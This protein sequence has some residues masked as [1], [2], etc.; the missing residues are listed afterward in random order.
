MK[1][2]CFL[3]LLSL[4]FV[5]TPSC[6][7]ELEGGNNNSGAVGG[8]TLFTATVEALQSEA[9]T[10]TQNDF[11]APGDKIKLVLND[12]SS[13]SANLIAGQGTESG[14]F[15]GTLPEGKTAKYAVYPE[16][17]FDSADGE[18]LNLVVPSAQY[19]YLTD[20]KAA[21]GKVAVG[22]KVALKNLTAVLP[23]NILAGA[24]VCKVELTSVDGSALAGVVSVSFTEEGLALGTIQN[25]SSTVS[26]DVYG[27]GTY[28]FAVIPEVAHAQ[29]LKV[30]WYLSEDPATAAGEKEL[31]ATTYAVNTLYEAVEIKT[32]DKNFYV[33]VEGAGTKDGK[34]WE[35]A[36]SA[37][38][39]YK[40]LT[41]AVYVA[42]EEP[43]EPE[44]TDPAEPAL[45]DE[46]ADSTE[47]SAP[48][49]DAFNGAT[50]H[51]AAGTY[52][53]GPVTELVYQEAVTLEF[54]GGYDAS[55]NRNAETNVTTFTG[56]NEHQ[57]FNFGSEMLC[58]FDGINFVEGYTEYR[59][60]AIAIKTGAFSFENCNFFDNESAADGGAMYFSASGELKF[61]DC[62]FTG[63]KTATTK[64]AGGL[65]G[66]IYCSASS[67]G[68]S[69]TIEGGTISGNTA[70]RGGFMCSYGA[71]S[72][73]SNVTFTGNEV[74]NSGGAIYVN[75]A[76]DLTFENCVFTE[77][78][79]LY[80]GAF[81][82]SSDVEVNGCTFENNTT[83]GNAGAI[84]MGSGGGLKV[85]PLND[86]PTVFKNNTAANYSGAISFETNTGSNRINGAH[87]IGNSAQ[88]GGALEVYAAEGKETRVIFD[89]CVF[90]GNYAVDNGGDAAGRGGAI[91]H[92]CE[93][94]IVL[95]NSTLTGNYSE[96]NGGAIAVMGWDKLQIFQT[97]FVGNHAKSGG[98]IYT[99]GA[100]DKY[101]NLYIDECSFDGNYITATYGTTVNINGIGEFCMNNSSIRGSY[102]TRSQSGDKASWLAIDV[103][104]E[105]CVH[106]SI[107]NCS[108]IGNT[109]YS[110]DGSSFTT[111]S[112]AG[113]ITLWGDNHYF[114]NNIIVPEA[115]GVHS[116]LGGGSDAIDL[117]YNHYNTV[118]K[119]TATDNG[120]NTTGLT[121]S[122]FGSLE[123][124]DG[125]WMWNGQINGAAPSLMTKEAVLARL[126]A[127]CPDFVTW[128]GDDFY[129]DQRY[130]DRGESWWPGAYQNN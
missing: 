41:D 10:E 15:M 39:F 58:K 91:F 5:T 81:D 75:T 33:T 24:D 67:S 73:I 35:N 64:D 104:Y 27:A 48:S 60:G 94:N 72:V 122:A 126:N 43:V 66:A 1:K 65:G 85:N 30:S 55:G 121:S 124:N 17:A 112:G 127:I 114:T 115:E 63:N 14:S 19:G 90:E 95:L 23:V 80:G 92:E 118:S 18:G 107:S 97:E 57:I 69:V 44:P 130:E 51:F 93:A 87:F 52:N 68:L 125:C 7:D 20:C 86:K 79:A 98:A 12:N 82:A 100:S 36:M 123:W 56:N 76:A 2:I 88:W 103:S 13:L 31:E 26:L 62:D 25:Q 117:T 9:D 89:G 109:Q 6:S 111:I 45:A 83:T 50:F 22:N 106:S 96:N 49:V 113:L 16:S 29:G 129:K 11:W 4:L 110:S 3:S 54:L 38:A 34:S 84:K 70:Y 37:A 77:N 21:A 101:A 71:K 102:N 119:V 42:P 28:Y 32:V 59:G 61:K 120:G 8:R 53:F 105:G 108:I 40:M 78:K 74:T 116:I 47:P 99:E 128:C 46:S